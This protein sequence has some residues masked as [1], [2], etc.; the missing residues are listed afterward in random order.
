[1][2][3]KTTNRLLK[4]LVYFYFISLCGACL[5]PKDRAGTFL[6]LTDSYNREVKLNTEPQ[7][8]ISLS[9]GITE[10]IF[11]LHAENKL[12]GISNYCNFP[13]ETQNIE[14]VGGLQNI[15]IE[16]IISLQ[17]DV[18]LIGSII[19]KKEVEKLEKS[20]IAVIALKQEDKLEGMLEAMKMLG[21]IVN[22]TACADSLVGCYG[23]RLEEY[24][25]CD[26]GRATAEQT[27]AEKT[28]AE[29]K[30]PPTVYYVVSFGAAG[31]F[32]A[33]ANSHINEII[34]YAG[35]RNIGDTLSTWNIS[36]EYLFT[37]NPDLIF[38]RP[39]ELPYFVK[40]YPYNLLDAVKENRVY[41]IESGWIDVIS[42][43]NFLA[44]ELMR[45]KV[46]EICPQV[47]AD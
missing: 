12:I 5:S 18:V 43:R 15:N 6:C 22:N 46:Q 25:L 34:Q 14:K 32:T 4:A 40:T 9:P 42:P 2:L 1:V 24:K 8:I 17:P 47:S 10:M 29:R 41:P 3:I 31:D 16:K 13:E 7:K 38:I 28:T 35:G 23:R 45:E 27:T 36:R 11:L 30:K 20:G 39:E 37:Q 44:I 21:Q 19:P 33:P 26:G